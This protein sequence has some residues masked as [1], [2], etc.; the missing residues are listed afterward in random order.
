MGALVDNFRGAALDTVKWD[1][2]NSAGNSGQQAGGQYTFIVQTAMTGDASLASDVAYNL[3]GSHLHIELID[4]GVQEAGLEMYPIILTQNP[5]NIT[6]SLVMVVSNGFLGMYEYVAGVPTAIGTPAYDPVAHR[7][8]RIRHAAGVVY[9][10]A[11]PNAYAWTT[12][13][14]KVPTI[15][16]TALYARIRA[17]CYLSLTT[18]KTTAVSNVNYL[19]PP[20]V[21]FPNGAIP[22]GMEIAYGADIN[23]DQEDW[24]W[25]DVTPP[26]PDTS[27]LMR[28]SITVTR[29]RADE[30]SD[31]APTSAGIELD[32]PDGDNTP[33]NPL[34]DHYPNVELGTPA[35][36]WIEASTPR[37]YLRPVADSRGIVESIAALNLTNDLDIRLDLFLRTTHSQGAYV[38][39]VGRNSATLFS[40]RVD[41]QPDRRLTLYWSTDGVNITDEATSDAPVL[42]M[43]ARATLRVTLDVNNG[44]GGYDVTFY[45]GES[46]DGPFNQV[47][48]VIT[49]VGTTSIS[50]AAAAFL[51]GPTDE[52]E[53]FA[54]QLGLDASVYRVQLRDGINGTVT[55]DADFTAQVSGVTTFVDSTGLVWVVTSAAEL[56]NRWF[57]I[58]GTIDEWAPTWPWGDLSAQQDGGLAEG[59]AR[60]DL[61]ISGLLR[62]LG[63][64]STPLDSPLVLGFIKAGTAT[65]PLVAYWPM[66]DASGSTQFASGLAGGT[67]A[68]F[69]G[70]PQLSSDATLAGSLPLPVLSD[71]TQIS[72]S[73]TGLFGGDWQVTWLINIPSPGPG[74]AT[75]I[76]TVAGSPGATVS[77]WVITVT[78]AAI[79]AVGRDTLGAALTTLTSAPTDLIGGWSR[80][81]LR[82]R[83]FGADVSWYL[84]WT[85]VRYPAGTP[86]YALNTFYTGILGSP[87]GWSVPPGAELGDIA[88]G[89]VGVYSG[90]TVS[91]DLNVPAT[92]NV[93]ETAVARMAR[94][95]ADQGIDFRV[96]GD[97]YTTARMGVQRSET[98]LALLR[99]A[100]DADGGVLYERQDWV[101]LVYRTRESRY[102]QPVNMTLDALQDQNLNPFS[103]ILDDQRVTNDVTVTRLGGSSVRVTD[104]VSA[105]R[106]RYYATPT[107]NLF[108]DS[109]VA[110]AA[111][112]ILHLGVVKGMRYPQLT[113]NLGVAPEVIDSW[114][115]VDSAA[116]VDVI[117]LPPQH[118]AAGVQ[119][120]IEG[121][122]EPIDPFRWAPVMNCSPASVWDVGLLP[123]DADSVPDS[124]LLR[125]ETDGSELAVAIDDDDTALS[126]AVT[127]GPAWTA[128]NAETPFDIRIGGERIT[129]TDIAAP[130]GSAATTGAA[131]ASTATSVSHVA[132]SVVAPAIGDLLICMWTS[133]DASGTYTLPGGM[134]IGT[135]T[136]GTT[137]SSENATQTLAA[138]GATGTR[139]ATF[140][141]ARAWSAISVVVH[142]A[143][144]SPGVAE[145]VS[146]YAHLATLTLTTSNS[147]PV[148]SWL[149]VFQ[150]WSYDPGNN[151]NGPGGDWLPI[152]DSV[153]ANASTSRTR[154]WAR[155][156]TAAGIQSVV[157]PA[158][159]GV[160]DNH[161]RIYVLTGVTGP[162]QA[163]TVTRNVNGAARAHAIGDS[164]SLWFTPVLAR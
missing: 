36:W 87:T 77:L 33:D 149:I 105:A 120:A 9:F 15:A 96:I 114:L 157:L 53:D 82:G 100:E 134:V 85:P 145:V 119:V 54:T 92:G 57:R 156:V 89:H 151:M 8:L 17:F 79:T 28:Q 146:G 103:P 137:S 6:N 158:P 106:G 123:D 61:T 42:P 94:L 43:S 162:T 108:S 104:E 130:A 138:A 152:A 51:I 4:A 126:V 144:G 16:I 97:P 19:T 122:S 7:W 99:D 46:V 59:E 40:W 31:V 10:E 117:N 62:R 56:S 55:V 102:N 29:G 2:V 83:Q 1:A 121:Y 78:S 142:A 81:M 111:G 48:N 155:R 98:F 35:R 125:L 76:M 150:A 86:V 25:F 30:S 139:T 44:A 115:T 66:E 63:Q 159:S 116:R 135:R 21:P 65:S 23:G 67:P 71:D 69:S 133:Y 143:T 112:W 93:G 129:V 18:A 13:G 20:D 110:D 95:C 107:L 160:S 68:P 90:I 73:I 38:Q 136:D 50:N 11:S 80:M 124:Y 131:S 109:Q 113:T 27:E 22:V 101:G 24:P 75:T 74:G 5:A 118:P 26:P 161:G 154:A 14:S 52:L 132:P 41:V 12:L 88:M 164:V 39:A 148:G 64:G 47:G 72:G 34:S 32:N 37:L 153:L 60:V 45:V 84:I 141:S 147:A 140:N 128:D 127:A 49:G 70:S 3:T 91:A 58:V 163:F